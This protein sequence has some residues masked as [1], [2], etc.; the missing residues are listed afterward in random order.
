[1][2]EPCQWNHV[3]GSLNPADLHSRGCSVETLISKRWWEGP[4]WLRKVQERWSKSEE[5]PDQ[6]IVNAEKKK[7][8]VALLNVSADFRC[9]LIRF[10]SFEKLVR[11]TV[12]MIRF[13]RNCKTM[14]AERLI[15]TL[16]P[17]ELDEAEN[18]ILYLIFICYC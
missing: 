9:Y 8:I 5:S 11:V 1:M 13:I 6:D 4:T 17:E 14:K 18:K 15:E 12:W 16:T 3:P 10:S 7:S 2:S